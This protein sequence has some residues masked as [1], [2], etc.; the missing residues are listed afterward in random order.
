VANLGR[1]MVDANSIWLQARSAVTS[2]QYPPRIAYTIAIT[3][4]DGETPAAGHYRAVCSADGGSIRV[5]PISDEQLAQPPDPHG[6][7]MYVNIALSTGRN[8]PAVAAL[9]VGHP[10]PY[11]DFLGW[12]ILSPTYTFGMR[13][14]TGGIAPP[15]PGESALRV[16]AI[17]SAQA[18]EY[19][20]DLIDTPVVDDV[21]TYH[22]RLTPLRRPKENRLRELWVGETDYLPRRAVIAG[23]FTI[24][25]LVDVPWTVDF[26]ILNGAPYIARE[27]AEQTLYFAHHRVVRDAVVAFQDIREPNGSLYDTP[28]IEPEKSDSA[29][30]E[31]PD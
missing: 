17:V 12:P 5:F 24:A 27:S 20:V 1:L 21:T 25:P 29:L 4:V 9:P 6:V 30:T 13:Y 15:S 7:N 31:P 28:L 11:Q 19:R 2:A 10:A 26:S 22:L 18:P 8:A 23:N 3:G 16:I 14:G